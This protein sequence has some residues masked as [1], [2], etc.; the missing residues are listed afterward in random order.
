MTR[1]RDKRRKAPR[2][3][4]TEAARAADTKTPREPRVF[5]PVDV[6]DGIPDRGGG[7]RTWL[8]VVLAAV[9]V[10]WLAF[11]VYCAFAARVGA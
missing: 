11:L 8:R 10:G 6:T 4:P 7:R 2:Q 5:V 3:E 9:F 1:R